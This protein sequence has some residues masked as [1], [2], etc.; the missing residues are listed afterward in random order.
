MKHFK[1]IGIPVLMFA[2]YCLAHAGNIIVHTIGDSTMA[3]YDESTTDKRGWG[4]M[5]QQFFNDSVTVN[6]R[7]KSGASSKSFY[8][9][10][11]YWT[12]VKKQMNKGD[13]VLIQFAH[14]DEKTGGTDGDSL[15]AYYY[16]IKDSTSAVAVDYRGTTA[17][18]TYKQFLRKYVNETRSLGGIP[19]LVGPMCRK[20]FS[21]STITRTGR[22]DL[23]DKFSIIKDGKL[24]T[25]QS[26]ATDD[27]TYDYPYQMKQ[28]AD[29]MNVPFIDLT[30]LTKQAFESYGDAAC[31]QLLFCTGDG[32]HP[33]AMGGTLVARLAAKALAEQGILSKFINTSADLTIYPTTADF[34]KAYTGQTLTKEFSISGFDLTPAEGTIT[35]TA[36]SGFKVASSKSGTYQD[37][38]QINYSGGNVNYTR[39]YAQC[40]LT[41]E[42]TISGDITISNGTVTKK[43]TVSATAIELTGGT[44]ATAY[45]RLESDATC[46]LD[47]PATVVD[48]SWSNMYVQRYSNPNANTVWPEGSGFDASRKTQRNLISGD[49]WPAGEIDEVSTRY[50]QFGLKANEGTELNIDSIGMY[51]CGCGGNGMRCRIWYS[52]NEDFSD[53]VTIAE[54]QTMKANNMIAVSNTPVVCLQPGQSIYVRIYPWYS[55]SA[56][57]KTICISDVTIRGIAKAVATGISTANKNECHQPVYYDINGMR[58]SRPDKGMNIVKTENGTKKII[59]L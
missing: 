51:I 42:G 36:P 48:E 37:T 40:K 45:W 21:G 2:G 44:R 39:F 59:Y 14:N 31:T 30:T 16:S 3:N 13:Y 55:S 10:P 7:G 32:T 15:K 47:G 4:M 24:L 20:Y 22:H 49:A 34:G 38:I 33:N 53:A 23:G 29:E 57:G 41:T 50:I 28:V 26:V 46:A 25:G 9:E 8:L 27:H 18:D 1:K 54:Y 56:T 6:N 5:L 19:V 52:V 35:I 58:L 17:S 43:A 12:T 11:A